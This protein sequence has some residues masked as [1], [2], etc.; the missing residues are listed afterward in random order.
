M[1]SLSEAKMLGGIGSIL[2]L[3]GAPIPQIGFVVSIV[4]L[5]L[6]FIAI[7]NISEIVQDQSIFSNFLINFIFGI[8]AIGS[9]LI[10]LIATIGSVGGISFFTALE[11]MNPT[12]PAEIFSYIQPL[13]SGCILALVVMWIV[14]LI[15]AI[16]L[17]KSYNSIAEQTN[18]ETFKTTGTLYLVGTAS[19]IFIVGFLI[20]FIARIFE[21]ISFFSIPDNPPKIE[22][23]TSL[24]S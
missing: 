11:G 24:P 10:V 1:K 18:V 12:Q 8:L 22:D 16:Y 4:G 19:I 3:V 13:L 20:I 21:I 9:V 23:E 7:K 14:L 17:R 15:G 2:L 6:Q 5:I